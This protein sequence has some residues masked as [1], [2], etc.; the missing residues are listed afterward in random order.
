MGRQDGAP[1]Q[2]A[3]RP[4]GPAA[5]RPCFAAVDLG[6]NNCRLLVAEADRTG[7]GFR[8]VDGYSQIVRLGEGLASTGRFT[9]FDST[10]V[11][12]RW[13]SLKLVRAGDPPRQWWF[14]FDGER[15]TRNADALQLQTQDPDIY[16][17]VVETLRGISS[18]FSPM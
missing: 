17:W 3:G 4:R 13:R 18:S 5:A 12:G 16:Q 11:S 15:L 10:Q 9:L 6:T 8:V 7:A 1:A 14:A 2:S